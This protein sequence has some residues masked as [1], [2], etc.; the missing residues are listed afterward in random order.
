MLLEFKFTMKEV[1]WNQEIKKSKSVLTI[2]SMTWMASMALVTFGP[3]F[4]WK[5]NDVLS[6]LAVA[7][8]LGLGIGMIWINIKHV[9]KLDDLQKKIQVEAGCSFG[10]RSGWWIELF[11]T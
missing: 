11:V 5:G 1:N 2:W 7:L 4:L 3:M 10:S 8:N 6:A 9:N